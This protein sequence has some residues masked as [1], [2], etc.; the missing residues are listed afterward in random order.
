VGQIKKEKK[1]WGRG[2]EEK[3]KEKNERKTI[4]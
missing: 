1:K 3:R 2:K 4:T